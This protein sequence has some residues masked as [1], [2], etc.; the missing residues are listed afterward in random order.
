V[1]RKM[2]A[3][4]RA[5]FL[6]ALAETG[7]QTL[8]AEVAKVSR[9]WVVKARGEDSG[10]DAAVRDA[11]AAARARLDAGASRAPAPGWTYFEG[12]EL[13]VRGTGGSRVAEDSDETAGRA[14]AP[15]RRV[16][17]ARAR[18]KQWTPRIEDRF[19]AALQA[20]CNVKAALAAV[21]MSKGS[22]H[23]HRGRW[24]GFARRWREAEEAGALRL[25]WALVEHAQNLASRLALP[26]PDP[27]PD[28]SV[29]EILHSLYLHGH[30]SGMG[31][32]PGRWPR[33]AT[34]DEALA[35]LLS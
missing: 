17:V 25:E 10:F 1:S 13:V 22:A 2:S 26:P 29:D 12:E 16:Q 18:L 21:G 27:M 4:R 11:V 14:V 9:S 6:R 28:L 7:N 19:L 33:G 30:L 34:L 3:G 8:A 35:S 20:T 15:R 31:R 5:G 32:R 23:T 24:P